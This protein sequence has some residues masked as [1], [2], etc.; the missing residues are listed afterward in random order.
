M[1]TGRCQ[2]KEDSPDPNQMSDSPEITAAELLGVTEAST[3]M[4]VM[5]CKPSKEKEKAVR[6]WQLGCGIHYGFVQTHHSN[7]SFPIV[8]DNDDWG[9]S[10]SEGPPGGIQIRYSVAGQ[11]VTAAEY[12]LALMEPPQGEKPGLELGFLQPT[13]FVY[14]TQDAPAASAAR[15]GW[16]SVEEPLPSQGIVTNHIPHIP[17]NIPHFA[18]RLKKLIATATVTA[19][20]GT[21]IGDYSTQHK[22]YGAVQVGIIDF[23]QLIIAAM[24]YFLYEDLNN[25]IP[26]YN[27]ALNSSRNGAIN[28]KLLHLGLLFNLVVMGQVWQ[29]WNKSI[30]AKAHWS[31]IYEFISFSFVVASTVVASLMHTGLAEGVQHKLNNRNRILLIVLFVLLRA[32]VLILVCLELVGGYP[33][34]VTVTSDAVFIVLFAHV[35]KI[36]S[37]HAD[38]MTLREFFDINDE[39]GMFRS[40]TFVSSGLKAA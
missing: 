26:A 10:S 28:F 8:P 24:T 35:W 2:H 33:V 25:D 22:I 3:W 23:A 12:E 27:S 15:N 4:S 6:T 16:F 1:G 30:Q 32:V 19:L 7:L 5:P 36:G 13:V 38:P 29:H 20:V 39:R 17:G 37:V 40:R 11:H 9:S 31:V 34:V 14:A 21:V 18:A